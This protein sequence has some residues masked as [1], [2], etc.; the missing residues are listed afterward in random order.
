M[1]KLHENC[2]LMRLENRCKYHTDGTDLVHELTDRRENIEIDT[3]DYNGYKLQKGKFE[4]INTQIHHLHIYTKLD[5]I[6]N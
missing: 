4:H 3:L 2:Q 1:T 5:R 6:V